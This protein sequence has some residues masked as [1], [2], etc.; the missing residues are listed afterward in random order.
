MHIIL[1]KMF[2][3][4]ILTINNLYLLTYLLTYLLSYLL[5]YLLTYLHEALVVGWERE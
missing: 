2:D 5:T 1:V 4:Y 3:M